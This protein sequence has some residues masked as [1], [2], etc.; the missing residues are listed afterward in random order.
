MRKNRQFMTGILLLVTVGLHAQLTQITGKVTD[1]TGIPIPSAT[2]RLKNGKGDTSGGKTNID[3][4]SNVT[5][6][7]YLN[8]GNVHKAQLH[9]FN[10]DANNNFPGSNGQILNNKPY[11]ANLKY[12]GHFK[13]FFPSANSALVVNPIQ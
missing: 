10:T 5:N 6:N 7:T 12:Y 8:I 11:N 13:E 1:T 3:F 4:S 9:S 2:I